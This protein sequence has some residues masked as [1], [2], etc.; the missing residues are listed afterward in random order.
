V[1][2][3]RVLVEE[4]EAASCKGT[5]SAGIVRLILE[6]EEGGAQFCLGDPLRGLG[7]MF[8]EWAHGPGIHLLGPLRQ[9]AEV[10]SLDHPLT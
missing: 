1:P 8:R 7:V 5:G 10:Q 9:A 2:L 3:A 6:I 4:L